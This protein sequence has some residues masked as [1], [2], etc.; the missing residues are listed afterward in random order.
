MY[1]YFRFYMNFFLAADC[2]KIRVALSTKFQEK[3]LENAIVLI[4]VF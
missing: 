1:T 3:I 4:K 2:I